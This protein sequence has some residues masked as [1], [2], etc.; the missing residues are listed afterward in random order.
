M[1]EPR[2]DL[3][4]ADLLALGRDAQWRLKWA[5]QGSWKQ[6]QETLSRP[7]QVSGVAQNVKKYRFVHGWFLHRLQVWVWSCNMFSEIAGGGNLSPGPSRIKDVI[8][9]LKKNFFFFWRASQAALVVKNPPANAGDVRDL[10][11]IPG[12]GRSPG[13]GH[14][15]P[16][17]YSCLE[18]PMDRGVCRATVYGVIKNWTD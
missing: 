16:L 14:G 6:M 10:G 15:N 11:S 17:N 7:S 1:S 18:N 5:V 4:G 13:G 8:L 9:Y 12:S 3:L 2:M